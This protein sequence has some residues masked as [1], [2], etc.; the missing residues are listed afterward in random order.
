MIFAKRNDAGSDPLPAL[1]DYYPYLDTDAVEA[2]FASK[3]YSEDEKNRILSDVLYSKNEAEKNRPHSKDM[4]TDVYLYYKNVK[5]LAAGGICLPRRDF[6]LL[7]SAMNGIKL[8]GKNTVFSSKVAGALEKL[9]NDGESDAVLTE[10]VC[11]A[12]QSTG[13]RFYRLSDIVPLSA[14]DADPGIRMHR[15]QIYLQAL[16]TISTERNALL[17]ALCCLTF[18]N[19]FNDVDLECKAVFPVFLNGTDFTPDKTIIIIEPSLCTFRRWKNICPKYAGKAVFVFKD[20]TIASSLQALFGTSNLS[21]IPGNKLD[22]H[23]YRNP[24]ER[25]SVL[26]FANNTDPISEKADY[27]Q[28]LKNH[29]SGK[30]DLFVFASDYELE[31]KKSLLKE[32]VSDMVA[33]RVWTFPA[34][35]TNSTRPQ[36]KL[37]MCF[38]YG[39]FER[40]DSGNDIEIVQFSQT[41]ENRTNYY[42]T[43]KSFT[44]KISAEIYFAGDCNFREIYRDAS[45]EMLSKSGT[46]RTRFTVQFSDE[47][48]IHYTEAENKKHPDCVRIKAYIKTPGKNSELIPE[49]VRSANTV[50]KGDVKRWLLKTYPYL[51]ERSGEKRCVRDI[52]SG[53]GDRF[54]PHTMSLKTFLYLC[55]Q[56]E[57]DASVYVKEILREVMESPLGQ[58]S[59]AR[60]TAEMIR[61]FIGSD[62]L[63][64]VKCSP[65]QIVFSLRK[66]FDAAVEKGICSDNPAREIKEYENEPDPWNSVIKDSLGKSFLTEEEFQAEVAKCIEGANR[67]D[68]K[69]MV[70]LIKMFTGLETQI[71]CALKWKD[72][73]ELEEYPGIYQLLIQRQCE[74]C[75]GRFRTFSDRVFYRKYPCVS[76]LRDALLREKAMCLL[77]NSEKTEEYLDNCT[78]IKGDTLI[79]GQTWVLKPADASAYI[80]KSILKKLGVDA[81]LLEFQQTNNTTIEIDLSYNGRDILRESFAHYVYKYG[82][83]ELG[84]KNY[85]MG[86]KGPD[87]FSRNYVDYGNDDSQI[88][89]LRKLERF[90]REVMNDT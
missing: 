4:Q 49:T 31:S 72:F 30:H 3:K 69:S 90:C 24:P 25:S 35:I 18:D 22:E 55:P 2:F 26:L 87:T 39:Y 75:T 10:F 8:S 27:I 82:G 85:L 73:K 78:I 29:V 65:K 81:D 56:I 71:V 70:V 88:K 38:S 48:L 42:L 58:Y 14:S 33:E 74:T 28:T 15:E 21:I 19:G 23:L 50:R 80:R 60:I 37:L 11:N 5:K 52:V 51:P 40:P 84:E 12:A 1:H 7:L 77:E 79:N 9:R 6:N 76:V 32:S 59:V 17:D 63:S 83:L 89:I 66:A 68:Y 36:R 61:T 67:R 34:G 57:R 62:S 16:K 41:N 13:S 45:M 86:L 64:G 20:E 43:V 54:D 44:V 47:I 53:Y 46:D